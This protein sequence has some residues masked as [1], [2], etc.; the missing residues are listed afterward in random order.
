MP[1]MDSKA[2]PRQLWEN[3]A[4]IAKSSDPAGA[5][6]AIADRFYDL[7]EHAGPSPGD[8]DKDDGPRDT[9]SVTPNTRARS[10]TVTQRSGP[11]L[12]KQGE[13]ATWK[14]VAQHMAKHEGKPLSGVLGDTSVGTALVQGQPDDALVR[15]YENYNDAPLTGRFQFVAN[16]GGGTVIVNRMRQACQGYLQGRKAVD[17]S[18]FCISQWKVF[19]AEGGSGR[20]DSCVV[21]LSQLCG[22]PAVQDFLEYHLYPRLRDVLADRFRPY[23]LCAVRPGRPLWGLDYPDKGKFR[24]VLRIDETAVKNNY[25]SAGG[26]MGLYLG[27]AFE[28]AMERNEKSPSPSPHPSQARDLLILQAQMNLAVVLKELE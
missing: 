23:G 28:R 8:Q 3:F 24:Q 18:K 21:Y 16:F 4:D 6:M 20:S 26:M 14:K 1:F 27:R 17:P 10:N 25:T 15:L 11:Y 22:S 12:S 5:K 2:I 19:G 13:A 7:Y 9:A